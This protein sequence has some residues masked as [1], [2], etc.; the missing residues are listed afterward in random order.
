MD[1]VIGGLGQVEGFRL[2]LDVPAFADIVFEVKVFFFINLLWVSTRGHFDCD[3]TDNKSTE[4][5]Y[6]F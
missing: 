4:S 3:N 6:M 1:T 5:K 2:H